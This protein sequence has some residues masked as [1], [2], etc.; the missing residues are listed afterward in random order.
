LGDLFKRKGFDSIFQ[1]DGNYSAWVLPLRYKTKRQVKNK[2]GLHF[3][4]IK[5][6]LIFRRSRDGANSLLNETGISTSLDFPE[7]TRH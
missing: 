4:F 6:L 1:H 3:V 5:R 2:K 7:A